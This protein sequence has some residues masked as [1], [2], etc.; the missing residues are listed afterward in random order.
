MKIRK[1]SIQDIEKLK[2]IGILTF[3][4][5]YASV[6]SEENM[7]EY[8]DN[9]FSTEELKAGLND[10]NSEFYFFE[11]DEKTI[12]YLKVNTGQ[13]QTVIKDENALEIE[14]IYVLKE[15]QGKKVGQN[16]Y[17]QAIKL[18]EDK[19]Y[20]YVWLCVWEQNSRAIR[21]YEK[22]GFVAFDKHIFKLGNDVQTDIMMKLE[23]NK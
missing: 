3:V 6:N 19:N 21:F 13:S 7:T 12:G 14:R 10:E 9:K 4:E 18:A 20:E 17:E 22:N 8:L 1:V 11:L 23:L 5:T 16:L 15:F 2:D